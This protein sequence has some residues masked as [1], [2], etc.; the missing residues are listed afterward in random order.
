M[1]NDFENELIALDRE[2][3]ALKQAKLKWAGVIGTEDHPFTATFIIT[4]IQYA[5]FSSQALYITAENSNGDSFLSELLFTGSW[6][7]RGWVRN[8]IYETKGKTKWCLAMVIPTQDDYITY[9]GPTYDQA[10]PFP[11][12]LKFLVRTTSNVN[13]TTEW[14]TNPYTTVW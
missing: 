14:G 3:Q 12:T 7:G 2:I 10:N 8:K 4:E 11:V 6:D 5:L 9:Y 1:N 13:V